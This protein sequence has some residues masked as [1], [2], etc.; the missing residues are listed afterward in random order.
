MN[1][2][3]I[4]FSAGLLLSACNGGSGTDKAK[5]LE[6]LKKQE[7]EL[8]T[9]IE[10]LEKEL[11]A[12]DTS[13][14]MRHSKT[15]LLTNMQPASF[16]HYIEL[17]GK[18]DAE[19]NLAVSAKMAGVVSKISVK[20][21][22]AVRAGQVLAELDN[23]VMAQGVEEVKT[24]LA[25]ATSLYAKQKNLWE[26]KIGT[27]V[28]YLSAKNNKE[29][30]EKKLATMNEQLEMSQLKSPINGIVDAVDIKLGQALMPGLPAVRVVNM[31]SLK[32]KADAAESYAS[33][34]KKGQK[35]KIDFPDLKMTVESE[36][37]HAA[38]VINPLTR[39]FGIEASLGEN[40]DY[41]P[42]MLAVIK[43]ADYTND[44]SMVVPV[45]VVQ[46]SDDGSYIFIAQK[47][48]K[49][50][51]AKK[52]MIQTGYTYNSRIEIISGI[53]AGDQVITTGFQDLNDGDSVQL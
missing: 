27:E 46:H 17:Q 11:L 43:V 39:T 14:T 49:G 6:D 53:A 22:D 4:I 19:E 3:V 32:V 44:S 42:N 21:G 2:F 37:S 28:Q 47:S 20:P 1:K 45:N 38:R 23:G 31:A 48:A 16:A 15:V 12:S 13:G 41:H 25:F 51:V 50:M 18:V 24:A 26:Q 8:K 36:I 7:A 5:E 40:G 10:T 34:I 30:L 33:K 35:V 29:S 52:V 9:K